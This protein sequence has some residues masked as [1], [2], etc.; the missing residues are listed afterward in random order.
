MLV[1]KDLDDVVNVLE[2][3]D[4]ESRKGRY[5]IGFVSY[6]AA[7]AFD[8]HLVCQP[9][10]SIPL[11]VFGVFEASE[12]ISLP[13]QSPVGLELEPI[14]QTNSI[15]RFPVSSSIWLMAIPIR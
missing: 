2:K 10:G 13:S 5:C 6:E 12:R 7:P 11:T 1:A 14:V 15:V 8:A 9:P 3:V 4:A